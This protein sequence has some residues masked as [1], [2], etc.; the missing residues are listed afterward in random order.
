MNGI[1]ANEITEVLKVLNEALANN[2]FTIDYLRKE[3][4]EAETEILN[5]RHEN[6]ELKKEVENLRGDLDFYKPKGSET[7]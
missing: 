1:A 3:L 2:N 4:A 7:K 5:L 6:E